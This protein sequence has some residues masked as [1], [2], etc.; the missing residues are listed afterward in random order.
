M[1]TGYES[2]SKFVI[3]FNLTQDEYNQL[4]KGAIRF[5]VLEVTEDGGVSIRTYHDSDKLLEAFRGVEKGIYGLRF[6]K[7]HVKEGIN[8]LVISSFDDAVFRI[9]QIEV[10]LDA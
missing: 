2:E 10:D 9:K 1:G 7:R 4:N 6:D 8:T 5:K 3:D